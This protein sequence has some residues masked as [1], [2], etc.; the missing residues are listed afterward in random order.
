MNNTNINKD[1][2]DF[3]IISD[4]VEEEG[5]AK[6]ESHQQNNDNFDIKRKKKISS[7]KD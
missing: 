3:M 2:Y 1:D 6:V 5:E 4:L 7:T